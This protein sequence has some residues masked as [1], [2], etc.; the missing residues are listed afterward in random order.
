MASAG[1]EYH[2]D[3]A[4]IYRLYTAWTAN[5]VYMHHTYT[6]CENSTTHLKVNML[7]LNFQAGDS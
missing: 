4:H 2:I 7:Q 3:S 1:T 6:Y 5:T